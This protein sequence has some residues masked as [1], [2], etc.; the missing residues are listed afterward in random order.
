[1]FQGFQNI[2]V[3]IFLIFKTGYMIFIIINKVHCYLWSDGELSPPA[4]Q[5]RYPAVYLAHHAQ[6][7]MGNMSR[8]SPAHVRHRRWRRLPRQLRRG[9]SCCTMR[10]IEGFRCGEL[11]LGTTELGT[12]AVVVVEAEKRV[13]TVDLTGFDG[14][15]LGMERISTMSLRGMER[16]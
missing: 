4:K 13:V 1:M 8:G 5:R 14:R 7:P 16:E 12:G 6:R 10:E 15:R 9:R 2:L 3:C 11:H